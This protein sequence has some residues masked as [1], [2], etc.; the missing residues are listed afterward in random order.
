MRNWASSGL[1]VNSAEK[2]LKLDSSNAFEHAR[3]SLNLLSSQ[4]EQGDF[5]NLPEVTLLDSGEISNALGAFSGETGEIYI[6]SDWAQEASDEDIAY[7]LS[8]ELGHFLDHLLNNS[9]T[10]G[11]EGA[12]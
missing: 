11:D 8:E 3:D 5:S 9:D 7:V 6:N 4:W 1:L 10:Y 12:F 2:A